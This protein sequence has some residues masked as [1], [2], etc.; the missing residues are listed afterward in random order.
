MRFVT[1]SAPLSDP[2]WPRAAHWIVPALADNPSCDIALLGIPAYR[3]SITPTGAHATPG[4]V[5]DALSR[6]STYAGSRGTDVAELTAMDFGDVSEPDGPEGEAR[7]REAVAHVMRGGVRLLIA[8][9][10][11]NS[12]TCPVATAL[13][14]GDLTGSGLITIDAHHDLRDGISNGS[15]V[16]RLV[17][18]GLPGRNIVQIGIADFSN[19]AAYA[20][21]AGE[22]G[23]T[24][25][26]RSELATRPLAAVLAYALERAGTGGRRIF[27]DIDVDVCD[28]AEVPG[29]PSAAPGGLTAHQLRDIA[30]ALASDPRVAGIDITEIDATIDAP[31]QRTVRLAALLVLEAAAGLRSRRAV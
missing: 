14:G 12:I 25:I 18:A 15:P 1:D 13:A 31:D 2:L 4:A 9:G 20:T 7:V 3:T 8:L 11:D 29:C 16:R 30:F 10:G 5:R 21:R 28:R 22:L 17:E 27:V 23:I 6:Y 24:V 19:S 26:H